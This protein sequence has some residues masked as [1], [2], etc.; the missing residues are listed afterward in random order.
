[1]PPSAAVHP[2][3][4]SPLDDHQRAS[5]TIRDHPRMARDADDT[6]DVGTLPYGD[7]TGEPLAGPALQQPRSRGLATSTSLPAFA[8]SA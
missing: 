2:G 8:L 4:T 5:V 7:T 3:M 1:M 6:P